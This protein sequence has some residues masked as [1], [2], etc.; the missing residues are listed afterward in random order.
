MRRLTPAVHS[1][2]FRQSLVLVLWCVGL[3]LLGSVLT[4]WP[5]RLDGLPGQV[6]AALMLVLL[7]GFLTALLRPW[8]GGYT[9]RLLAYRL[10]APRVGPG[11]LVLLVLAVLV[12]NYGS[13][14]LLTAVLQ[15]EQ[16]WVPVLEG[17]LGEPGGAAMLFVLL[18]FAA[19]LVEEPLVR[20]RLQAG[21]ARTWGVPSALAV[22]ATVF[23]WLHGVPA[24][25]PVYV[26][27]GLLLGFAVWLTRSV[28]TGVLIHAC[29]NGMTL[30]LFL[31]AR[32]AGVQPG[33]ATEAVD[34]VGPL[35]QAGGTAL[36]LGGALLALALWL[37][38]WPRRRP[39]EPVRWRPLLLVGPLLLI[40]NLLPLL[41]G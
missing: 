35:L 17:V 28:W 38:G 11:A 39:A 22:S 31:L 23:A 27:F 24:L 13:L 14:S 7:A 2:W 21:V 3:S 37:C 9:R 4:Q 5:L 1:G 15:P 34:G 29:H 8:Q 12:L 19:P 40:L 30:G 32:A 26:V 33:D 36:V 18:V 6:R 20:G 41:D 25:I 10:V 16:V